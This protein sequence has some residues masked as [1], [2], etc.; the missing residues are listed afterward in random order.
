[1]TLE[2]WYKLW[3][4]LSA[5]EPFAFIFSADGQILLRGGLDRD[6]KSS[7]MSGSVYEIM[8]KLCGGR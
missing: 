3:V 7:P 2:K 1:M 8:V 5:I 4:A 6:S